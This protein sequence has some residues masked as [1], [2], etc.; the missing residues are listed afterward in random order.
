M[1][2]VVTHRTR[3]VNDSDF[4]RKAMGRLIRGKLNP[5]NFAKPCYTVIVIRVLF[6][7]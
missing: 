6:D 3:T 2:C 4:E 1:M 7:E 5:A